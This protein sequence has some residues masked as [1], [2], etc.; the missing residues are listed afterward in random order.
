M[1]LGSIINDLVNQKGQNKV[2]LEV[3]VDDS[4]ISRFRSATGGLPLPVIEELLALAGVEIVEK[5]H[6]RRLED[7]LETVSE[8]WK[9]GRKKA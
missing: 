3:G 1:E 7:A 8:L 5:G 2:A 6:I 9:Q 4:A